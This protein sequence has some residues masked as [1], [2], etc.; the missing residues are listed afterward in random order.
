MSLTQAF[1]DIR[2]IF[3]CS[4]KCFPAPVDNCSLLQYAAQLPMSAIQTAGM[5]GVS[6][7]SCC[8]SQAAQA[9]EPEGQS[10]DEPEV[11]DLENPSFEFPAQDE[12][13]AR[14]AQP[15]QIDQLEFGAD[16]KK[17]PA[18]GEGLVFAYPF[19]IILVCF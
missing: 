8:D 7:R 4:A 11:L 3:S 2:K 17:Q 19:N 12:M 6:Q 13:P 9:G 15:D 5:I 1:P 14:P 16:D 10:E 18:A